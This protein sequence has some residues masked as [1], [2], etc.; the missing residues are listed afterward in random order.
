MDLQASALDPKVSSAVSLSY[1]NEDFDLHTQ[2]EMKGILDSLALADIDKN[3][4]GQ[5][6]LPIISTKE[7]KTAHAEYK[8]YTST[9][10]AS[11]TK[12]L[13]S[14]STSQLTINTRTSTE[15]LDKMASLQRDSL[16]ERALKCLMFA[17]KGSIRV[18][19]RF[20]RQHL[21]F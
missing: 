21:L 18:G 7:A 9:N 20:N 4:K 19:R 14:K 5:K 15:V 16:F 3:L 6:L 1:T 17:D 12:Y 8:N 13:S 2:K 10:G 11:T